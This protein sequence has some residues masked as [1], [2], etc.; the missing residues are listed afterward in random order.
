MFKLIV[1][2]FWPWMVFLLAL[3]V[4]LAVFLIEAQ[5][6]DGK[7]V[8]QADI[9]AAPM[10]MRYANLKV[11]DPVYVAIE[12]GFFKD[13]NLEVSI[14]GDTLG[15]PTA[16]QA[17]A[18]GQ[19]EAGLS[20]IPALINANAAGL[21]VTGVTD[22]QSATP[23]QPLEEYFVRADSGIKTVAD[24]KGKKFAVNLIKSSF[25]YTAIMALENAGLTEKDVDFVLL[26]FDK[27]EQALATG[28][29]D[30]IGLMEPYISHA[31]SVEG[32]KITRLFTAL[33]VFGP[34][35]FSDIFVNRIWAAD[36]PQAATAFASGI[37]DAINWIEANQEEA[38]PIIAKYTGID[39]QY[40]PAYHFQK[41]GTVS[42]NDTRFWLDYMLGHKDIN[43]TWLKIDSI[44]TNDYNG[45]Y[46]R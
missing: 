2:R 10:K 19:A 40:I 7:N 18:A 36:H 23:E 29:V 14:L 15:G 34:K 21:P 45:L 9:P 4:L 3:L 27:Q 39:Q 30:V 20:S 37:A 6:Q 31:K 11:Y 33:D 24:L 35:Q 22:I 8:S 5:N 26:P 16:I 42:E 1:K 13:R 28:Q 44:A 25:H 32:N 17:V 46:G 43:A 41:N 12:K 38:K